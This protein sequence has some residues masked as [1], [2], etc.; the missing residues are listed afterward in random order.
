MNFEHSP[1]VRDIVARVQRFFEDE[2]LPYERAWQRQ[3]VQ[4]GAQPDF[5]GAL[6][7]KA[8]AAGL[9]NLALPDL[10]EDEPGTRLSNLA[11]APC[12]EI[13]GRLQ[14][15]SQVF[16]C[17]APEAP[18]MITLQNAATPEQKRRWLAPLLEGRTRS[19]FAFTEPEVASSDATNLSMRMRRDGDHYVLSGRKW[20]IT[21]GAHPDCSFAIT[22]GCSHPEAERNARHTAVVVPMDSPGLRVVRDLRFMGWHDHVAPIAEM[23]FEEVRVPVENRLGEEGQGFRIAQVRLGPARIHHCMRMLGMA[24]VMVSLM[25]ARVRERSAF[26]RS[27][28]GY[29][30]VQGWVAQSRMEIEQARLLVYR[31]A[32]KI[33]TGSFAAAWPD[34]SMAKLSVP[35]TVQRV[36]DRAIQV[37]GAMGGS[38]D[39]PMHY[40]H[41][42]ARLMRIGDGPDEVHQRQLFKQEATPDWRIA[43]SPYLCA[44][45]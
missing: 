10:A 16:N 8:R 9:W 40:A 1:E 43:E 5:L 6:Q 27:L 25:M 34:V 19:C 17:H 36:A 38:D 7:G 23:S 33:D 21:G 18:N 45:R 13:M 28:S 30:T 22:V 12:A 15:G 39:G 26:G 14:W 41:T 42:Y 32:W 24:E 20:Y 35:A 2:V 37:F 3:V 44:A 4:G 11:F 31:A 29:D